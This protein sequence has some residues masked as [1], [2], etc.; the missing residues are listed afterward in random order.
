L[1]DRHQCSR[2]KLG[3]GPIKVRVLCNLPSINENQQSINDTTTE[4]ADKENFRPNK[5]KRTKQENAMKNK[6]AREVQ[7]RLESSRSSELL[8][9]MHQ[10]SKSNVNITRKSELAKQVIA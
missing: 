6:M 1:S 2:C 5:R 3:K 4:M 7:W 8:K 10:Q 9:G